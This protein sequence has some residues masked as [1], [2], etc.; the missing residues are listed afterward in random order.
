MFKINYLKINNMERNITI[1]P[2]KAREW[3]NSGNKSLL[4]RN[5]NRR[6]W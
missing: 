3:Y 5:R 2:E 4:S 6:K 1:T